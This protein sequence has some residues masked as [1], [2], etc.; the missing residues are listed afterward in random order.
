MSEALVVDA[1]LFA[2]EHFLRRAFDDQAVDEMLARLGRAAGVSRVYLF[3]NRVGEDGDLVCDQRHEWVTEGCSSQLANPQLQGWSYERTGNL[4]LRER[5]AAG[6]TISGPTSS[7]PPAFRAVLVEQQIESLLITPVIVEGELWGYLGFDDCAAARRWSSAEEGA[8]R[9]ASSILAAAIERREAED[10]LRSSEAK[11]RELFE[12][13]SDLAW[14]IDSEGRFVSTNRAMSALLGFSAEEFLGMPWERIIVDPDHRETVRRMIADKL[15]G[16]RVRTTY[17]VE[18]RKKDGTPVPAEISSRLILRHGRPVGIQGTARDIGERRQLEAQLRMAQKM[19]AVGRLA[20]GIAHD[21]NNLLTAINGYS[22]R[23]LGRLPPTDPLRSEI[24]EI[25]RAGERAADLTR[26]LMAFSRQQVMVPKRLDVNE[27]VRQLVSVLARIVGNEVEIVNLAEGRLAKVRAD[28]SLVEQILVSLVVNARDAM[29]D[30]GRVEI[31]TGMA[32]PGEIRRHAEVYVADPAYVR[33]SIRDT[34][35]GLD[36]ATVARLFEPFFTTRE[37]GK[38]TGLGLST[39]YGMAKQL[40]GFIF[41][42]SR[43]GQG[44]V[45]HV[46][47]PAAPGEVLTAQPVESPNAEVSRET[48]LLVE[49]EELIRSLASQILAERGYEVLEAGQASEAIEILDRGER[50]VHLLLTDVVMPGT[51]GADL[52][53]R[54]LRRSP[55]TKILYMSGYSDSLVFRFGLLQDGA[56][57]LQKPFSPDALARKVRELLDS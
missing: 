17:E 8:L 4:W 28:P 33:L 51:S 43:P 29:P 40:G 9:L 47:L 54:V 39:V 20:G 37:L 49:D 7:L 27:L 26:E 41:V 24:S 35:P 15:E 22:E 1:V 50:T 56:G 19:E 46:Y 42:N 23:I 30:G 14:A 21:F 12:N 53:Q 48:I 44:S 32:D 6:D 10:R 52:A 13:S 34:G 36:E 3:E 11:Y 5:L 31:S 25:L 16:R 18:L 45:F 38:G 57:F 2:A 55:G